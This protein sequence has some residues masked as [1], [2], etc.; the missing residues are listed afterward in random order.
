MLVGMDRVEAL[1]LALDAQVELGRHI[2]AD[3]LARGTPC[4]GW[5]VR[6]VM[7]HSIGVTLKF[8]DFAAGATIQPV[9]PVGDLVGRDHLK[10]LRSCADA[11][12]AAWPSADMTRSCDL[13]FGVF[14][15]DL[16]AG[17]NLFDAL[18]HTWDIASATGVQ[19][20]CP[21]VLWSVGLDSARSVIGTRRD[22][23]HYA[24]EVP[25]GPGAGPRQRFL[26]FLGRLG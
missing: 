24:A 20:E 9:A 15:A 19:L 12:R 25:V 2:R 6:E 8:A 23:A 7:N 11:A 16:A 21:D 17:I 22:R 1:L 13:P 26:G 4:E 14:S 10:A 18:A 3:Q 5:Y